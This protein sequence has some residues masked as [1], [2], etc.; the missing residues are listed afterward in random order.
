MRR[1]ISPIFNSPLTAPG[2]ENNFRKRER[3]HP[4]IPLYLNVADTSIGN[5]FLQP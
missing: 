5:A 4:A 1:I 2:G 3:F